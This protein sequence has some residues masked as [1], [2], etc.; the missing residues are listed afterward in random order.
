MGILV[1]VKDLEVFQDLKKETKWIEA[2]A[3]S[4]RNTWMK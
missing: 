1:I 2:Q 4:L 3:E